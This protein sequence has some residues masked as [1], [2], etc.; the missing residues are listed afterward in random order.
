MDYKFQ[1]KIFTPHVALIYNRH[2]KQIL[3]LRLYEVLNSF[4][5]GQRHLPCKNNSHSSG[6][7][8]DVISLEQ[9]KLY[10]PFNHP[11]SFLKK[12]I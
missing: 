11:V 1:L 7:E 10:K 5:K 8:V 3:S 2:E 6:P 12:E 4:L 9:E